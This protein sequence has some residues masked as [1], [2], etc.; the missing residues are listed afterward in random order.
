MASKYAQGTRVTEGK[1][2]DEIESLL[3]RSGAK[4]IGFQYTD[5]FGSAVCRLNNR[6][7]KFSVTFP[8]GD[9]RERLRKWRCLL[10]SIRG[11]L[12]EWNNGLAVFDE[13]FLA[14]IVVNEDGQTVY[15]TIGHRLPEISQMPALTG[16]KR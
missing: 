3:K 1:S 14:H 16:G 7:L 2:R 5:S 10:A 11:R 15:E 6:V 4:E 9:E 13:V 8:R 12:V